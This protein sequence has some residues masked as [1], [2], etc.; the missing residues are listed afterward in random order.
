MGFVAGPAGAPG[1]G[2]VAHEEVGGGDHERRDGERE[3]FA[4][5][6]TGLT[7]GMWGEREGARGWAAQSDKARDRGGTA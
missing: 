7:G 3:G 5:G 1:G 6:K 2:R 4:C